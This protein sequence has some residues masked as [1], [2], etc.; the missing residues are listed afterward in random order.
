MTL[1]IELD[2]HDHSWRAQGPPVD[3]SL[4][5]NPLTGLPRAWY[6]GP[7]SANPV[8]TDGWVGS[9][10][11]GG[12][13]NFRDITFN[14]HAHGTHTETREH[15]HDSAQPIDALVRSNQL[16]F[17]MPALLLDASP[18]SHGDDWVV[19]VARLDPHRAKINRWRPEALVLRCT[20]GDVLRDWTQSN[21]PYLE[22]GFAEALV[23]LG[24]R[25]LL[26]DLPSVD[27]EQDDGALRAHRA[28]FG[29]AGDPREG[30]TI[31]ELLCV[32]K[33]LVPGPGLLAMQ[34]A[35]FVNDAAPSRPCWFTAEMAES[36]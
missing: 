23:Q 32:P 6:Q 34:I 26:I 10:P 9:I 18:E 12:D 22:D 36:S 4:P 2:H 27:R 35:P 24:I 31:S 8:R 3:L 7:P 33:G 28:F 20:N 15:I 30:C 5:V 14:P 13:V 29:G 1:R 19:P 17:L 16:P 25:H 21:P 11:E